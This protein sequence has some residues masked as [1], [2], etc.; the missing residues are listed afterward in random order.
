MFLDDESFWI[1]YFLLYTSHPSDTQFRN[2]FVFFF[3]L[4]D[5]GAFA[6]NFFQYLV[7]HMYVQYEEREGV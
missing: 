5:F 1:D 7:V 2:G 6:F 3:F 4:D